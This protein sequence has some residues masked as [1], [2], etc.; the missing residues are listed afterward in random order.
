MNTIKIQIGLIIIAVTL[1]IGCTSAALTRAREQLKNGAVGERVQAA[2]TLGDLNESG[3][4]E[5]LVNALS[6]NEA[7]VRKAVAT[8]LGKKGAPAIGPVITVLRT[9]RTEA[10]KSAADALG[11]IGTQAYDSVIAVINTDKSPESQ[12]ATFRA[13]GAIGDDRAIPLLI[14][15]LKDPN[16][17]I[18]KSIV[19]AL[20]HF[21]DPRVFDAV[22]PL[23]GDPAV[24]DVIGEALGNSGSSQVAKLE[25]GLNNHPIEIRLLLIQA[26]GR[27]GNM[28]VLPTLKEQLLLATDSGYPFS[29]SDERLRQQTEKAMSDLGPSAVPPLLDILRKSKDED[30]WFNKGIAT[31]L[32]STADELTI[33]LI[34][35]ELLS[36]KIEISARYCAD[37]LLDVADR[38]GEDGAPLKVATIA[39]DAIV[40]AFKS[41]KY[42][43]RSI[44]G[45]KTSFHNFEQPLP[46]MRKELLNALDR[47]DLAV[48]SG[49]HKFFIK[50]GISGSEDV[51]VAAL[52][53]ADSWLMAE[54]FLN[55]GNEKLS[56]AAREWATR[57]GMVVR[58]S[59]YPSHVTWGRPGIY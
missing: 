53:K 30:V 4:I 38:V 23:L 15:R 28:S 32:A 57:H 39:K 45:A 5:A 7:A 51:L 6:D 11:I 9:G 29:P 17:E 33:P 2:R 34:I 52:M 55:S 26:L 24:H 35:E 43:V 37:A 18:R 14:E 42:E 13:L 31:A 41:E 58:P 59:N 25:E 3:A 44:I 22:F 47:H 16:G 10:R 40:G 49:A 27:T 19:E 56:K 20:G 1:A 12:S 54:D 48:V 8:A 46:W 36:W 50:E 21:N